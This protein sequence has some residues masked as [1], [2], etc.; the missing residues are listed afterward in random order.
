MGKKDFGNYQFATRK[1]FTRFVRTEISL[2]EPEL[3]CPKLI[4]NTP[5]HRMAYQN[6][7]EFVL[8]FQEASSNRQEKF[9]FGILQKEEI[10]IILD[11]TGIDTSGFRRIVDNF[12]V[13]H[14]FKKHGYPIQ[15]FQEVKSLL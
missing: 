7:I 3:I 5:I 12:G 15:K 1:F 6:I 11:L 10:E 2:L 8:Q 13:R 9:S 14:A 4:A